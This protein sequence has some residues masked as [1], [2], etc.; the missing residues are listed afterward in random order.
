MDTSDEFIHVLSF[1]NN[2][3]DVCEADQPSCSGY[4]P[5]L[6][7]VIEDRQEREL[8]SEEQA[9]KLIRE[10]ETAKA[11]I[12]PPKGQNSVDPNFKSIA[13]MDQDYLVM[14]SHINENTQ[15]NMG[16]IC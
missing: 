7:G 15:E 2:I 8:T 16:A 6:P 9:D 11:R 4:K 5:G 10:A 3:S 13:V 14:G 1:V 12:F